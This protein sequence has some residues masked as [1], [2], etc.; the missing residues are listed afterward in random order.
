M[1]LIFVLWDKWKSRGSDFVSDRP[2]DGMR[3]F[4]GVAA[5]FLG[6]D[7]RD[8]ESGN[9]CVRVTGLIPNSTRFFFALPI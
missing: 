4:V 3:P 5:T 8:C 1:I 2:I 6:C 7:R 9:C